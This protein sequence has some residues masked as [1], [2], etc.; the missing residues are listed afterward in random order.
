MLDISRLNTGRFEIFKEKTD[1][2]KLLSNLAKE[3]ESQ[4][5]AAHSTLVLKLENVE[6]EVDPLRIE[7]VVNNLFSN[8][9]KYA[10]S[11]TIEIGLKENV[12]SVMMWV[13][14]TGPGIS[15]EFQQKI[16]NRYEREKS[17]VAVEGLGLG[18]YISRQI[19]EAHG[20]EITLKSGP[21]IGA[22]FYIIFNI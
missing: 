4:I 16:F 13:K 5:L 2:T 1:L 8:A 17:L 6:L 14:D 15:K 21:G 11:S 3:N 20:G 18:L 12:N 19:I 10:P 7:Q 22:T 9:I